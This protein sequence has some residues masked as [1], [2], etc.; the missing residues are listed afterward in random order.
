MAA[1]DGPGFAQG[2]FNDTGV[3]GILLR[4]L[5]GF[6]AGLH[7]GEIDDAAFGFR[8]DFV[9]DDEDIAGLK[10]CAAFAKRSEK[11]VGQRVAGPDFVGK[12]N[13]DEADLGLI[14]GH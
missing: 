13:R 3:E 11:S 2:K 9:F 14:S 4:P 12:G 8:N 5:N 10:F 7:G 6:N 1:D